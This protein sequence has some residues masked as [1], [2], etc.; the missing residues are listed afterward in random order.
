MHKKLSLPTE[1]L[2]WCAYHCAQL[3]YTTQHRT[4]KIIFPLILQAIIIA[5]MSTG[6]KLVPNTTKRWRQNAALHAA[7]YN[8]GFNAMN[9][10]PLIYINASR[11]NE[12]YNY[13][14]FSRCIP[15]YFSPSCAQILSTC[16][17]H[18]IVDGA[19]GNADQV[20]TNYNANRSTAS[21]ASWWRYH[22]TGS[23]WHTWLHLN[24]HRRTCFRSSEL[25]LQLMGDHLCG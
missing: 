14:S 1:L 11:G 17:L 4:V 8:H 9:A 13:N 25:G 21:D 22:Y 16:S 7:R 20:M 24:R 12:I 3:S 15:V 18:S 5:Q 19:S 2:I 23:A 10:R 6:G